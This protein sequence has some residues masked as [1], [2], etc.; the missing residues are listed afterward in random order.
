MK[1]PVKSHYKTDKEYRLALRE[2][3]KANRIRLNEQSIRL[4]GVK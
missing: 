4:G 3:R 2:W 1:Y